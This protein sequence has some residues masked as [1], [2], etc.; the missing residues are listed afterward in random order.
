[1]D[2][3]ELEKI[4]GRI[5]D[6]R[7][8]YEQNE[9]AVRNQI[10]NPILRILGWDP[11]N[12]TEVKHDISTE[13]G[14]PDYSL[15]KQGKKL[16]FIEA[17]KLSPDISN[18]DIVQLARYCFGEGMKYGLITNRA[19]WILFK[20]FQEGTK[21]E[22][23]NIW[24]IDILTS[25]IDNTINHLNQISKENI[26]KIDII[27][28][29]Y[30]I[31]DNIWK[32][33]MNNPEKII[34]G[35]IPIINQIIINDYN[36]YSYDASEIENY[37]KERINELIKPSGKEEYEISISPDKG[38][39]GRKAS[40]LRRLYIGKD[41]FNINNTYEIL[42]NISEWLIKNGKLKGSDCPISSGPKRYLVNT[43]PIRKDG[44]PMRAPKPLSNGLYVETHWDEPV[45]IN[46]AKNLLE[47]FGY[48]SEILI[49]N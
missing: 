4:V 49:F 2:R 7:S 35:F 24:K 31:L 10:I 42:I 36:E 41:I 29:K 46:C 47:R 26:D 33:L 17:K 28:K 39:V 27:I 9:M 48:K 22:E 5:K 40:G 25:Y 30:N 14:K 20:S 23:R 21:I 38:I 45:T 32:S 1:M 11:E 43:K 18:K 3:E 19:V 6:H 34:E 12:P 8:Y 37:L 15:F 13:E 16:M 44:Q